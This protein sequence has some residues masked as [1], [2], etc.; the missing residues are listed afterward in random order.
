MSKRLAGTCYFKIDG[1]QIET[2]VEGDVEV[3]LLTMVRETLKP[4]YHKETEQNPSIK[5]TFLFTP[6]FPIE[7]LEG[8]V[9]MTVTV[10]M[11]NGMVFTLQEACCVGETSIKN[12]DG[13]VEL[14]FEGRRMI[15]VK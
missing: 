14:T 6:D 12:A 3:S 10:E 8:D 5:G 9:E 2:T 13:T 15:R 1:Q 4:G 11:A 7:K